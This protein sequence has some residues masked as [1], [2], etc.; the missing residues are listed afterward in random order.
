MNNIELDAW[1]ENLNRLKELLYIEISFNQQEITRLTTLLKLKK[2][3]I[4]KEELY[5]LTK[6][7]LEYTLP[8]ECLTKCSKKYLTRNEMLFVY[9]LAFKVKYDIQETCLDIVKDYCMEKVKNGIK[10]ENISQLEILMTM[11]A[12]YL[13]DFSEYEQSNTLSEVLL[14]ECLVNRRMGM[15]SDMLYNKIWNN[16]NSIPINQQ[17]D[18]ESIKKALSKCAVLCEIVRRY[19]WQAFFRDKMQ[20]FN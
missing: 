16:Q 20:S 19:N 4:N 13:G 2:K 8:I 15:L 5:N 7:A 3:E 11:L 18:N 1:E 6:C 17:I 10:P 14:K 12:S 9:D